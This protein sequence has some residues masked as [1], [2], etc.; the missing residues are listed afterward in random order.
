[1]TGWHPRQCPISL[2]HLL[3]ASAVAVAT[4][5][6]AIQD[7]CAQSTTDAAA[8]CAK[9]A[10]LSNFP[11]AATQITL[12]KFNAR[13]SAPA[14][15]VAL[16][17]HCQVQA[18]SKSV[19]VLTDIHTA[20]ASRCG[21]RRP[22][23]GMGASCSR[24]A[25]VQKARCRRRSALPGRLLRASPVAGRWRARTADMR[26]RTFPSPPSSSSIQRQSSTTPIVR[27]MLQRRLP[28]IWSTPFTAVRQITPISSAAPPAAGKAW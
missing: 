10:T 15:G 24:A 5:A 28:S 23:I 8:A 7:A 22:P 4:A 13:G 27:S 25:A 16:P 17:D 26:T 9:L 12:A 19:W 14:N 21:C 18:S 20:T 2:R 3:G 1:M 6:V 11:V